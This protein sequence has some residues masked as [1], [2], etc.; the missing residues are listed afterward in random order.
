MTIVSGPKSMSR[1]AHFKLTS[2]VLLLALFIFKALNAWRFPNQ[3]IIPDSVTLI[4]TVTLLIYLWIRELIDKDRLYAINLELAASR[5]K[6][7]QSQITALH[8]LMTAMEV[9]HP[10]LRGHC[11]RV[12]ALSEGI[13]DKLRLPPDEVE[14]IRTAALLHDIGAVRITDDIFDKK[15]NLSD[16]QWEA[17]KNHPVI[18]SAILST[19]E[20]LRSE[21]AIARGHHERFD[22]KGYPD[23]LQ[24]D[25]ISMGGRI[26]AL[27]EA[28]DAMN[29][30]RAYRPQPLSQQFIIRE[31]RANSGTQ[32]DPRVV[33]AFLE[34]L[35]EKPQMWSCS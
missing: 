30:P 8:T 1:S 4:I 15:D 21:S 2:V 6:M 32:F 24:G 23:A 22:G 13:A 29:S 34:L 11:R 25:K 10:E 31:I 27:A 17:I 28:F 26:V 35:H 3:E 14:I 19:S 12:T 33:I 7:K 18:S 5:E 16:E 9:K 20:L